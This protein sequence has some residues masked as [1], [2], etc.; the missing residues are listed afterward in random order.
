MEFDVYPV[1]FEGR[2]KPLHVRW[3]GVVRGELYVIEE[4]DAE[5]SRTIRIASIVGK[6][7][8]ERLL[9]LLDA[10]LVT[11][12]PDWWTMTGWER[13]PEAHSAA[14]RAC[15]QSWILIPAVVADR[16]RAESEQARALAEQLPKQPVVAS[17]GARR[18]RCERRSGSA[19]IR[20]RDGG[21][22]PSG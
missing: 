8:H 7:P 10:V 17:R 6:Q 16:E 2:L 15:A 19:L 9:V 14:M 1:R 3:A 18:R 5:L 20:R 22:C 12:K 21:S 13:I 4:R 11:A